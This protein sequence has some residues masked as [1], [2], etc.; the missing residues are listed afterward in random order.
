VSPFDIKSVLLAKHAQH[1]VMVHFPIALSLVSLL[2]DALAR[3]RRRPE[4]LAAAHY[5]LVGAAITSLAAVATGLAAWQ[6]QLGGARLKGNLRL[7]LIFALACTGMLWLL[8]GLRARYRSAEQP[9]GAAYFA[10][11]TTMAVAIALTGHLGGFV[12]GVNIPGN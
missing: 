2:F 3:W 9:P 4:L 5:N 11:A 10:V 7:H 12:S 1:V 6:W 8:W